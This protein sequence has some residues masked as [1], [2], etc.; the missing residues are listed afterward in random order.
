MSRHRTPL[1]RVAAALLSCVLA[2]F[3]ATAAIAA[4][5]TITVSS[6]AG[7]TVVPGTTSVAAGADQSFSIEAYTCY[8]VSDVRVDGVSVGPVASY[9]FTNVQAPHSLAV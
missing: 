3:C 2:A 8:V 4:N 6:N 1:G 9:T 7:G 5:F